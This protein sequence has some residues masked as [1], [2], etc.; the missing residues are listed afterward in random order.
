MQIIKYPSEENVTEAV[1]VDEPFLVV[2]S[3]D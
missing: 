3:F 2:I 1:K